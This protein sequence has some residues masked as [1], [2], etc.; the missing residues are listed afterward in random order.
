MLDFV[1][2]VDCLNHKIVVQ[3]MFTKL[4][5]VTSRHFSVIAS[6]S[7]VIVMGQSLTNCNKISFS[8]TEKYA[9]QHVKTFYSIFSLKCDFSIC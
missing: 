9:L 6:Y 1:K 7:P 8:D 3:T 2:Y 4:Y 5:I